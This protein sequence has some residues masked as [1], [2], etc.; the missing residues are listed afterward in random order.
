MLVLNSLLVLSWEKNIIDLLPGK[1]DHENSK[2]V[3]VSYVTGI[4]RQAVFKIEEPDFYELGEQW[5]DQKNVFF[6]VLGCEINEASLKGRLF[7]VTI[8]GKDNSDRN[9]VV[10]QAA[11]DY[12]GRKKYFVTLCE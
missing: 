5:N 6:T 12:T 9:C 1:N 11:L 3:T 10:C 4:C 2:C 8:G 7:K